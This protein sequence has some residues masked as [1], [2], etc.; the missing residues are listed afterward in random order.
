[1]IR[2]Q[3]PWIQKWIQAFW[4]PYSDLDPVLGFNDS[5]WIKLQAENIAIFFL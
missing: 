1:M 2:I 4:Y 5:H 3:I